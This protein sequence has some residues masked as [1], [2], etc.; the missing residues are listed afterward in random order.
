MKPTNKHLIAALA[1]VIGEPILGWTVICMIA[2]GVI[3]WLGCMAMVN[4]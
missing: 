1:L 4:S 3:F 2:A